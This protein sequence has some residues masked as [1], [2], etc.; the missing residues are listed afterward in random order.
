MIVDQIGAATVHAVAVL[1]RL[2]WT[3]A[4]AQMLAVLAFAAFLGIGG[5]RVWTA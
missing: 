4:Y 2:M 1:A 3:L 5:S